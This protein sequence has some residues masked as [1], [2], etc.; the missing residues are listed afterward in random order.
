MKVG[1]HAECYSGAAPL[2]GSFFPFVSLVSGDP[3]RHGHTLQSM[4]HCAVPSGALSTAHISAVAIVASN[5][6]RNRVSV[7][8]CGVPGGVGLVRCLNACHCYCIDGGASTREQ[9]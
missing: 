3:V 4:G 9:D 1:Q 5:A 7:L 8:N 2:V 6:P